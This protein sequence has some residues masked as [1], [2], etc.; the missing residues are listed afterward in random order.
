[1]ITAHHLPYTKDWLMPVL[2]K[3]SMDFHYDKHHL[4]YVKKLNSSIINTAYQ[5]TTLEAMILESY[6]KG[7]M[8]VFNNAAQ[9]WNHDFYWKSISTSKSITPNLKNLINYSFNDFTQLREDFIKKGLSLFGSG[10]IWL[11]Q[12][13]GGKLKL[14]TTNNA[15]NPLIMNLKPLLT[16]DLWEHSYYIDYRNDRMQYL[17]NIFQC[18]NWSFA[19]KNLSV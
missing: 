12:D 16:I 15:E 18:L 1:M 14:V 13:N 8:H 7:D 10:W 4:G 3:E 5:N 17:N 6:Q 9:I 2:S 11:I 19:D